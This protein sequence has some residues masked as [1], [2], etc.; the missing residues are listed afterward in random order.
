M[1]KCKSVE[2]Y[3]KDEK[4]CSKISNLTNFMIFTKSNEP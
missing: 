1:I 4:K 2:R 3:Y